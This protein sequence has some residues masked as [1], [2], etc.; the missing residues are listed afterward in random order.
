[1]YLTKIFSLS[2]RLRIHFSTD[3]SLG[4]AYVLESIHSALSLYTKYKLTSYM[5]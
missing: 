5:K 3:N 4:E 1:M 2:I